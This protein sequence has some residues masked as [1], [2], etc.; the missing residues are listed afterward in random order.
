M[1]TAVIAAEAAGAT[2]LIATP[3]FLS[4]LEKM[5]ADIAVATT[6]VVVIV[7][8]VAAAAAAATLIATSLFLILLEKIKLYYGVA[9]AVVAATAA[10]AIAAAAKLIETSSIFLEKMM[11]AAI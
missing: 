5:R 1:L 2:T 9:I 6:A 8:I 7:A 10:A 3:P 11:E 4:L